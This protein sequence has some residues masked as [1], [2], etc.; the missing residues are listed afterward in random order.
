MPRRPSA[1]FG[2]AAYI[3]TIALAVVALVAATFVVADPVRGAGE[4]AIRAA[5]AAWDGV[6]GN[7]PKPASAQR[8]IVV[9]STP[10]LADRMSDDPDAL[11]DDQKRWV[12]EADASQRLLIARLASRGVKIERELSFTRTLN[13]FSALLDPRAHAELE[14]TAGVAGVY[15]VRTVYP[16]SVTSQTLARAEFR[17]GG[18]RRPDVSLPGFDGTGVTIALLDSGV[19]LDHP[20]LGGRVLSGLDLVAGDRLAAAEPKPDEPKRLEEHGTR[21]AGV[22]VGDGGPAGLSGVAPGARVLPIRVLGWER[23]ADGSYALLGRGDVLIAGIE[24]AVD[25]DG[26]GDVE[27]SAE[28]ALAAVVEPYASFA[29]SPESRS[30]TGAALVGTLVVAPTGND[31]RAGRG[32]G[33]VGSPGGAPAALTV[34]ALDARRVVLAAKTVLR[35]GS[36]TTTFDSAARVLGSVRPAGSLSV[37]GLLGPSLA[38][39]QRA[40]TTAVGGAVLADFFDKEGVSRVAGRAALI[41]AGDGGLEVRAKN[42]VTAGASALLVYG[43]KL[44]AGALDLEE[45]TAIPVVALPDEEGR[46]ALGA[47]ARGEAVSVVFG[48]VERHANRAA[49]RVAPFSSG[50]VAFDGRV[51]PDIV[52]AGVGIA[53]ADAGANPDGTPRF[54]TATGSSVAAAVAAGAAALVARARPGLTAGELRSLLVGSAR[55][56]TAGETPDPVTLQGA[57]ALDTAAAAGAEVAVAPVGLAFGRADGAGWRVAQTVTVRNLSARQLEIDFGI[58]RDDWGGPNLAFAAGPA[59]LS[60]HPGTA[61]E[62]TLVASGSGRVSGRAA[63]VFLVSPDG[64]R[65]SRLPWAVMFRGPKQE[66]LLSGVA[67]AHARFNPSDTAPTVLAFRAGAIVSDVEGH[68]VEPVEL[69][70]AE[71]W[72]REGKRLGVLARLRDLLPG[73]YAFGLTG[74]GPNGRELRP[75]DYTLRLEAHPVAGDYGALASKVDVPFTITR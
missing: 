40:G 46:D 65:P 73:R 3:R 57:G 75:G 71:L 5:A 62:V 63:G 11:P 24:R 68:A 31:G 12:A 51:K 10:S 4:S 22:L 42:A 50:G 53:T 54:A 69:L 67:L 30:V 18:G 7:R 15:P 19:D 17:P 61:A 26:D 72:T 39:P 64:S 34:G 16:A 23:A 8:M 27:D 14:R 28:I 56:L 9:L 70:V 41:P 74:R 45:A 13:G 55:Q 37:R 59:H 44:P 66:E 20:Y 21:M 6:F 35:V 60:L 32:F 43:T 52:A 48:P 25:P 33:T 1:P 2:R 58:T 36:D 47:L 38:D 49:D 29:D